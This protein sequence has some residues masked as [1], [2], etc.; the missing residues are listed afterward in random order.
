MPAG[1]AQALGTGLGARLRVSVC[2]GVALMCRDQ[3]WPAS[4]EGVRPETGA[5]GSKA[6]RARATCCVAQRALYNLRP[7]QP[8]THPLSLLELSLSTL[9]SESLAQA[10]G[11][12]PDS[13]LKPREL[14]GE[15]CEIRQHCG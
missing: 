3:R 13:W 4:C 12:G 15:G 6:A 9:S 5:A 14:W 1:G 8:C 7:A 10:S 11:S 2:G